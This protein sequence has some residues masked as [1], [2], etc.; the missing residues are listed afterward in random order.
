MEIKTRINLEEIKKINDTLNI[1]IFITLVILLDESIGKR[2][3]YK[4]YRAKKNF[5]YIFVL[6]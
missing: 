2:M 3:Y 6:Y 5:I 4:T 1:F